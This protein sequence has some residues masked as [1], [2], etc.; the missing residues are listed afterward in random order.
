[1]KRALNIT[2]GLLLGSVM[3][4]PAARADQ[5][6]NYMTAGGVYLQNITNATIADTF[7]TGTNSFSDLSLRRYPITSLANG[8]NAGVIIGTNSF[9]EVSGPTAAFTIN[10]MTG[11]PLRDGHLVVILNQTGY[12]MTVAHQSG[13]EPTAANRIITMTGADRTTTGNGAATFLYNAN[14]ARWMLIAFDP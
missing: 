10:G 1:M 2:A 14:T 6:I 7:A 5:T 4:A 9:V 8:A 12:D 3:L 11:S 13:V